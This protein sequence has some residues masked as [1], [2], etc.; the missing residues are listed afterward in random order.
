MHTPAGKSV[1]QESPCLSNNCYV[2]PNMLKLSFRGMHREKLLSLL[3]SD[4]S[5]TMH[6]ILYYVTANTAQCFMPLS[7]MNGCNM[8]TLFCCNLRL[9][10]VTADL[11]HSCSAAFSA[12]QLYQVDRAGLGGQCIVPNTV[13]LGLTIHTGWSCQLHA[14]QMEYAPLRLSA[15]MPKSYISMLSRLAYST[16]Y[17]HI[18]ISQSHF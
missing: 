14:E 3:L 5:P 15:F 9:V 13:N 8:G 7:N 18:D 12:A 6:T 16:M 4:I 10:P 2:L 17:K 11:K 1:C